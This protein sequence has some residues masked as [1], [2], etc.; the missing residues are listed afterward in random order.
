MVWIYNFSCW[1]KVLLKVWV[2]SLRIFLYKEW[3]KSPNQCKRITCKMKIFNDLEYIMTI[4]AF[5]VR[6]IFG[7]KYSRVD[8]LNFWK[9]AFK[10]CYLVHSWI[11]CP[12]SFWLTHCYITSINTGNP[13][14]DFVKVLDNRI[15]FI[16]IAGRQLIH[17]VT[18]M[19]NT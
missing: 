11:L 6:D 13:P 18:L 4:F 15:F 5:V 16:G 2:W 12:I 10:K 14:F 17:K 8:Q 3:K 9:T 19:Q 7:R 1:S